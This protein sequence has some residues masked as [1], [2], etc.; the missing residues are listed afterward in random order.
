[1]AILLLTTL[2][3]HLEIPVSNTS[4]DALLTDIVDGVNAHIIKLCGEIE[5]DDFSENVDFFEGRGFT[6][7]RPINSVTSVVDEDSNEYTDD[8]TAHLLKSGLI[9]LESL[10]TNELTVSYNAGYAA[11]PKDVQLYAIRLAEHKYYK[12]AGAV[13]ESAEGFSIKYLEPEQSMLDPYKKMVG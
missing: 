4:Q 13:S 1:M 6:A 12:K 2:K 3:V 5:V 7:N 10:T 11:V 8:S 9:Q